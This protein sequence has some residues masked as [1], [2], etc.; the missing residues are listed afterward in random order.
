M[1]KLHIQN[2]DSKTTI[3]EIANLLAPYGVAATIDLYTDYKTSG[4]N[5]IAVV[6]LDNYLAEIVIE[7]LDG[8]P[9]KGQILYIR[10]T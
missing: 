7:C 3:T 5:A 9:F 2:L 10:D 6:E 4:R 8:I 1:R